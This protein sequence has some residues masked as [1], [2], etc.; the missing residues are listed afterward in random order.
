[1]VRRSLPSLVLMWCCVAPLP[2]AA[3]ADLGAYARARVAAADGAVVPAASDYARALAADPAD[4]D[5]AEQA[6]RAA[7]KAGDDALVD[8]ALTVLDRAGRLPPEATPMLVAAAARAHDMPAARRALA[9]MRAT[10]LGVLVPALEAW[11][12]QESGDDPFAALATPPTDAVSRRLA[13][14]TR[15]LLSLARGDADAGLATMRL[16]LG[17]EAA[18]QDNRI[19]AARLLVGRGD[20]ARARALLT[21]TAPAIV[22][23]R[24]RLADPASAAREGRAPS[25]AFG[26]ALLFTRIADDLSSGEPGILSFVFPQS[27]VRADPR[28]E[29]ARLLLAQA[30]AEDGAVDRAL[31]VLDGIPRDSVRAKVVQVTRAQLLSEA[32]RKDEALVIATR[33]ANAP[34]ATVA[35][36]QRL[37]GSYVTLDRPAEAV[38]LYARALDMA[39][40]AADWSDWL[41]YGAALDRAGRWGEAR[42]ALEH[43]LSLAPGEPL[44][45]NYLGYALV[46]HGERLSEA[47]AMLEKASRLKPDEAAITDSLGW[48][49]YRG[50]DVAGA[51]PLIERA[52]A[53]DPANAEIAEHLGDIYWATGRR[54]EARYAW[55]AA[56][57][58]AD[59]A[60]AA[61]LAGKIAGGL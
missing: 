34:D 9:R 51:L 25:L 21:G 29:G 27:A 30:L 38:P 7:I 41:Q 58:T 10:R 26:V 36:V 53:A 35:D 60:Q 1:M 11:A 45:L 23:L 44:V 18:G 50:G 6:W 42:A 61:R 8:R 54:F 32:G 47:R 20:I 57:Q 37:A 49:L 22:A 12:A 56:G 39:G 46:E 28:A 40:A 31:A 59:P 16:M 3:T 17:D 13:E 55:T 15:G 33:L 52:A 43:A 5:V 2:A 24:E 4:L 48:A 14:E 19:A